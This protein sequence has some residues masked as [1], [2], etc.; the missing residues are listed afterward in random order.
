MLS[1]KAQLVV[2]GAPPSGLEDSQG[3]LIDG[4]GNGQA[5]SNAVA[6]ITTNGAATISALS[7]GSAAVDQ[8]VELG[9][10]AALAKRR[11]S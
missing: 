3:R 7:G 10:L 2:N 9:E 1:T 6:I 4:N 8:L 5:G 11:K